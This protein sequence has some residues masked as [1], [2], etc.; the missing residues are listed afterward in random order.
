MTSL[1][2]RSKWIGLGV[3]LLAVLLVAMDV[4]ILYFAAPFISADLAPSG[5]QQLWML[6][7][8][9]FVLAGLLITMGS[10]ADLVGR[11]RVL[12]CGAG[13]FGLASAAAAFASTP[14]QLIA[15]RALMGLGGATLMPSSLALLRN[16]F[17]DDAERRKA[18]AI[19]TGVV[20]GGSALGPLLGGLLLQHFSW[21]SVFLINVPVMV[22]LV[23]AAPRLL[24]ES[25]DP[26]GARLDPISALLSLGTMLPLVFG[27]QRAAV[28]GLGLI[29]V[30]A[31]VVG[32]VGGVAFV[33]RQRA[34]TS[35]MIELSLFRDAR[36]SGAL[37]VNLM[38]MLGLVGFALF[39]TQ[40]L[41]SV[42]GLSPLTAALWTLPAPLS[43]GVVAPLA[44]VAAQRVRP[45]A[46]VAACFLLALVGFL[47]LLRV[48]ARDGLP[49]ALAG[50]V[51]TTMGLAGAMTLLTDLILG[52]APAERAGA[53]S[54]VAETGQELGGA[55][56][57]AVLGSIGTAVYRH[58]VGGG[59][60]HAAHETL[61]G[62]VEVARALPGRSGD[63]LLD[64]ARV[65]FTHGLHAAALGASVVMAFAA[66]VAWFTLRTVPPHATADVADPERELVAA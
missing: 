29:P 7:V 26:S 9:G 61:G 22:A 5:T 62:A 17:P 41:Q 38:A 33:R 32:V 51:L 55:I 46:V 58:D 13:A 34:L 8:Y 16:L 40:Y 66:A 44:M 36:F 10:L 37:G 6:D 45:A 23:V 30:L 18:V 47:V 60:P 4:T 65:A 57:V 24:P 25:R 19:W 52:A 54:A 53:A 3:L 2:L 20:S 39:S 14:D 43:V 48:P 50:V 35:P 21:G 15:C 42:L 63:A 56:G 27:L 49:V 28:D 64:T 12:V 31:L 11:R 59:V 1:P